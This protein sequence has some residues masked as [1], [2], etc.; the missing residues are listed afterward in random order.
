MQKIAINMLLAISKEIKKHNYMYIY[1]YIL[2]LFAVCQ[3][4]VL[5]TFPD[6]AYLRSEEGLG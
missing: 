2:M 5:K 6:P 3:K 1:I 4:K